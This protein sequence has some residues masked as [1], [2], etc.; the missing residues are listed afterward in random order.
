[1]TEKISIYTFNAH[2]EPPEAKILKLEPL[3]LFLKSR[4]QRWSKAIYDETREVYDS[5]TETIFTIENIAL[6]VSMGYLT[7]LWSAGDVVKIANEVSNVLIN[8]YGLSS[9]D[10][11]E[12][13]KTKLSVA[14]NDRVKALDKPLQVYN[15][16]L[17]NSPYSI[18]EL[19]DLD[20]YYIVLGSKKYEVLKYYLDYT[21]A[22]LNFFTRK[23]AELNKI[24]ENLLL[25]PRT[26][27][28][29]TKT[30]M[31]H[32][33]LKKLIENLDYAEH[34]DMKKY[35]FKIFKDLI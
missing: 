35:L 14:I 25:F 19:N 17:G 20:F 8:E 34:P 28:E 33:Q 7:P 5:V 32:K 4:Y 21:K 31:P 26:I 3:P 6:R 23:E 12:I 9:S 27:N 10:V 29:K 30:N 15:I 13:F 1:M 2:Y 16:L 24:F 22:N 11:P 18:E